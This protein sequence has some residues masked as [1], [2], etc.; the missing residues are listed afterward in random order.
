MTCIAGVAHGGKVTLG[1]DS[2]GVAGYDL[3]VVAQP[4]VFRAGRFV[5]GVAGSFRVAQLLRWAFQPPDHDPRLDADRYMAVEWADALRECLKAKGSA[6]LDQG[7]EGFGG[8]LLVGYTGRLYR[9][10]GDYQALAPA[11]GFAAAGCGQQAALG[12]LFSTR[13]PA[14]KRVLTALQAA[15]RFSAGVRAPFHVETL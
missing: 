8:S 4:K 11:D 13:G 2:A 3:L 14:A 10:A 12:S 5:Y 15:E 7:E 1:G 6:Q 9:V